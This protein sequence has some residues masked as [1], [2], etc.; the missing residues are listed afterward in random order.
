MSSYST[1]AQEVPP[2]QA[3]RLRV[4]ADHH[5][6]TRRLDQARDRLE[7]Y[8]NALARF[9]CRKTDQILARAVGEVRQAQQDLQVS[10]M[11][12]AALR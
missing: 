2:K 4:E 12:R 8:R 10:E 9:P 7:L 11:M 5:S 1:W 6:A 3:R